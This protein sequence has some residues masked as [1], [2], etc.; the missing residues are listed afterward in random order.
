MPLRGLTAEQLLDSVAQATGL[1]DTGSRDPRFGGPTTGRDELL[2]K[3]T[4][5]SDRPTESQTTIL[6]ALALMNGQLIADQTALER[7]DL[8][9]AILEAPFLDTAG[10]IETLYLATLSR[11]PKPKELERAI[12]FIENS[13]G[14]NR[15][16][17]RK[18]ALADVFWALLN[19]GEFLLN[20]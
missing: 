10:Q 4:E 12:G 13:D 2:S 1:R 18:Q 19:S 16:P 7:S 9:A 3:F 11:K 14:E 6:Q 20:H 15:E 17:A 5:Q 8:L